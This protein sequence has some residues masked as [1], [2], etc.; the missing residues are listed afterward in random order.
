MAVGNTSR[1]YSHPGVAL[2][3]RFFFLLALTITTGWNYGLA[4]PHAHHRGV[5]YS[6]SWFNDLSNKGVCVCV[7]PRAIPSPPLLLRHSCCVEVHVML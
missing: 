5:E 3:P 1:Y 7:L 4:K 2:C 6:S